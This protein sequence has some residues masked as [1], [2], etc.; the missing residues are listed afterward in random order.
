MENR[1]RFKAEKEIKNNENIM[2]SILKLRGVEYPEKFLYPEKFYDEELR[3]DPFNFYNMDNAVD[4]LKFAIDNNELIGVL[5]DDDADGYSSASALINYIKNVRQTI[6]GIEWFFHTEK[7]HGLTRET[8][9]QML[10]SDCDL[11][12]IPDAASNDF[13]EQIELLKRGKKIIILDHHEVDNQEKVKEITDTL[14]NKYALVNNQL[15]FNKDT[16]KNFVGAG[17]VYKFCEAFDKKYGYNYSKDIMDLVA[18]GQI[19]DASDISEYE[20][21][22][23]IKHGL[24]NIKSPIMKHVLSD[25]IEKGKVAPINLS[26]SIIPLINSVSRVGTLEEKDMILKSLL[27]YWNEN[28][29]IVVKRR[30]KNKLT[31]KFEQVELEWSLYEYVADEIAKVKNRQNKTTDKVQKELVESSFTDLICIAETTEDDIGYR[32]ITG[33]IANKLM[34]RFK[35]PTLVLVNNKNGTFSGSGRGYEKTIKDFREWCNNTGLFELAQG[36]GN[37]FGVV[38]KED[39]LKK[40]KDELSKKLDSLNTCQEIVYDVDKLYENKTNLKEVKEIND[41]QEI[42]GGKVQSPMFG[43]KDLVINRSCINQRGSVVTFFHN[44]LEFI[45]YKQEPDL[46]DEFV[47]SLGFQQEFTV[48]L[49]G[50][51]SRNEWSGRVKEQIVLDDYVIRKEVL[52]TPEDNFVDSNGELSF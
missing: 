4:L 30:R 2:E 13:E 32:S 8:F 25:R 34:S 10:E 39:N 9:K 46:V 29:I 50:S 3:T 23:F 11:L 7:S 28:E 26:F 27:G 37:A 44:G 24:S 40:L 33:L 17:M 18:L 36:H 42:F 12:I 48:D 41:N 14:P 51:P 43:Y 47:S 6:N 38:I 15:D 49:V 1:L 19:G 16:N 5:V 35:M 22:Y 20:I 21:R 52:E 31:G 45:A